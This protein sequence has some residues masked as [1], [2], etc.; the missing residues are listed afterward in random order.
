MVTAKRCFIPHIS[1][2]VRD[3][4]NGLAPKLGA[5]KEN[6][7][8]AKSKTATKPVDDGAEKAAVET[9]ERASGELTQKGTALDL[10][11]KPCAQDAYNYLRAK[12]ADESRPPLRFFVRMADLEF[13]ASVVKRQLTLD[14]LK[15]LIHEDV[16]LVCAAPDH[17][18]PHEF[19]GVAVLVIRDQEQ[20]DEAGNCFPAIPGLGEELSRYVARHPDGNVKRHGSAFLFP[21]LE[22]R[23]EG[24]RA[25]TVLTG[26]TKIPMCGSRFYIGHDDD[27]LE[28]ETITQASHFGKFYKREQE[29]ERNRMASQGKN[30]KFAH[31]YSYTDADADALVKLRQDR[32]AENRAKSLEQKDAWDA[33]FGSIEAPASQNHR[34]S[35]RR[36]EGHGTHGKRFSRQDY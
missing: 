17:E 9:K 4:S 16:K 28:V 30:P 26:F 12:P 18:A 34:P 11:R 31:V 22:R 2:Y 35:T 5:K 20:K 1:D 25:H 8:M 14:E 13:L 36:G 29:R 19:P 33:Q 21:K 6:Q 23:G 7:Q 10:V 32:R 24:E 3:Y 27:G 15:V